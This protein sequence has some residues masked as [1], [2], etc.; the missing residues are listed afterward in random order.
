MEYRATT[1]ATAKIVAI[2]LRIRFKDH[3]KDVAARATNVWQTTVSVVEVHEPVD[4]S[5]GA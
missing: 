4:L 1:V 3:L 2:P 5:A